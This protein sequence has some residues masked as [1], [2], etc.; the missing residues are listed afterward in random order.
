MVA[1]WVYSTTLHPPIATRVLFRNYNVVFL[2]DATATYP[3]RIEAS[4]QQVAAD[5]DAIAA[6]PS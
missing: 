3:T 6:S 4:D 1:T 5:G 2:A